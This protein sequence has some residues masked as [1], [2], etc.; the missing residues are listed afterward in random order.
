M[1]STLLP[2]FFCLTELFGNFVVKLFG[3]FVC[4]LVDNQYSVIGRNNHA[5]VAVGVAVGKVASDAFVSVITQKK[6]CAAEAEGA[7]AV[8]EIL[9]KFNALYLRIIHRYLAPIGAVCGKAVFVQYYLYVA[10]KHQHRDGGKD[11]GCAY[12]TNC[13]CPFFV[14]CRAGSCNVGACF[15]LLFVVDI[16]INEGDC[17]HRKQKG[18]E[19][20]DS[21][22]KGNGTAERGKYTADKPYLAGKTV[23]AVPVFLVFKRPFY[24]Y[25][26]SAVLLALGHIVSEQYEHCAKHKRN[27]MNERKIVAH[28]GQK[29]GGANEDR[30]RGDDKYY[31]RD[32][33]AAL[34]F[35]LHI[36]GGN[37]DRYPEQRKE[38]KRQ[39]YYR[40]KLAALSVGN[41]ACVPMGIDKLGKLVPEYQSQQRGEKGQYRSDYK[42]DFILFYHYRYLLSVR[43]S[44]A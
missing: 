30:D 42:L 20:R 17:D 38:Y 28:C 41:A 32:H 9:S 13:L 35:V 14:L 12:Q 29:H 37:K 1:R 33:L 2:S 16:G 4:G 19:Y 44:K 36:L 39:T 7:R 6:P 24:P 10:G 23:G 11:N 21:D 18:Y 22:R 15:C 8:V 34:L 5:G 26:D 43:P 3:C 25:A 27:K 40:K 31:Q